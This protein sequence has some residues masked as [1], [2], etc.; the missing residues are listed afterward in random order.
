[1]PHKD[2]SIVHYIEYNDAAQVRSDTNG[3]IRFRMEG[4]GTIFE[5]QARN[6]PARIYLNTMSLSTP[7]H[8]KESRHKIEWWHDGAMVLAIS[9]T[10]GNFTI[11]MARYGG[12]EKI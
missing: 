10:E 4:T 2:T 12:E 3:R 9:G 5:I 8:S 1:M 6:D 11:G 7:R